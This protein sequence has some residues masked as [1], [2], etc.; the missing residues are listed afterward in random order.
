MKNAP[1]GT[2]GAPYRNTA[3]ASRG[4]LS[5]S[6]IVRTERWLPPDRRPADRW[7]TRWENGAPLVGRAHGCAQPVV[8]RR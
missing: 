3:T 8:Y 1:T 4:A 2:G 6:S 5:G 7:S